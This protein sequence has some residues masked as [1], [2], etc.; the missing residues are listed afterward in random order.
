MSQSQLNLNQVFKQ[1]L[2]KKSVFKN[3]ESLTDHYVPDQILHREGEI[4]QIA[5]TMAPSLRG[6]KVSNMFLYGTVGT[7]KSVSMKHV[8]SELER[9]SENV[10]ILYVNCKMK[11]VSD[12]EYRLLA[13]LIRKMGQMVPPTGLPT[14]HVYRIF[15]EIIDSEKQNIILVLDEID[16]LIQKTGDEILYNLTRI[17]QDMKNAKLSIVG[18]SNNA[19]F[20]ND[21][22][23]RV[24]SSLS[25]EEIIFKPY[26]ATQLK[27]I[28]TKRSI[29]AFN[30]GVLENGVIAKC[31]ALAAQE[32]G[33]ARRALDLLRMAGEIAERS[34]ELKITTNY[35][36]KAEEKLDMD[37][38]EEIIKSQPRQ[39]QAVMSSIIKLH[40]EG[41]RDIQ[42]GD[43]FTYYEKICKSS[44]LKP[45]TQR[46]ISDLV[47]ELDMLG[48]INAK[49]ISKGRYG[50]T[51]EINVPISK[52]MLEKIKKILQERYLL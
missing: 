25:E 8:A 3:K 13:E 47:G 34:G 2:Q 32:H 28:L 10:K 6:H 46:R 7:G 30:T 43:V 26:D 4:T 5:E 52:P 36:D 20:T 35:V 50:R 51:R 24:K 29:E 44:G 18:I 27:D 14:D 9:V 41:Q 12:T 38:I 1:Y 37:R 45:L 33:D 48:V 11:R 39:S 17:N 16:A 42:T 15:F 21:I 22:D 40:E 31:A 49:V 19:S 23:P